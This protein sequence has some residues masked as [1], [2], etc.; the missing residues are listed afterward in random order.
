M[1]VVVVVVVILDVFVGNVV[2]VYILL[3]NV[4]VEL[5]VLLVSGTSLAFVASVASR[6][7]PVAEEVHVYLGQQGVFPSC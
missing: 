1:F 3:L 6:R 7:R 4:F 2:L 5:S